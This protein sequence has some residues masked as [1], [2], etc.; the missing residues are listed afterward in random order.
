MKKKFKATVEFVFEAFNLE[1]D[2]NV[3]EKTITMYGGEWYPTHG[4]VN[5]DVEFGRSEEA[6]GCIYDTFGGVSV[7]M[8]KIEEIE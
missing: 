5:F 4:C 7:N 1:D 8:V 2:D 6:G 3:N